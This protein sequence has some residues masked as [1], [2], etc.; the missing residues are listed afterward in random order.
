MQKK[1][2]PITLPF[3]LK[4]TKGAPLKFFGKRLWGVN[5]SGIW[6]FFLKGLENKGIK[7][8]TRSCHHNHFCA[9][10]QMQRRMLLGGS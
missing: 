6:F 3:A 7:R 9:F 1:A 8:I 5:H 10:M 2:D 4:S